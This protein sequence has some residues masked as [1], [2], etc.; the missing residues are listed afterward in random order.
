MN[1]FE[2][3]KQFLIEQS[4]FSES[5]FVEI[6]ENNTQ[7]KPGQITTLE[8]KIVVGVKNAETFSN[9]ILLETIENYFWYDE[10]KY[11]LHI[12]KILKEL[13]IFPKKYLLVVIPWR[14]KYW[15]RSP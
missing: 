4:K 6:L 9:E 1:F 8:N 13:N 5:I 14:N 12:N 2:K 3:F 10:D 7:E 11:R 15:R